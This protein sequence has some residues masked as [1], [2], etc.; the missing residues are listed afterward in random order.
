LAPPLDFECP[1]GTRAAGE[2]TTRAGVKR[3]AA[4]GH[5]QAIQARRPPRRPTAHSRPCQ[6]SRL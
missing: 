6:P 1:A 3:R 2:K 4:G 5:R